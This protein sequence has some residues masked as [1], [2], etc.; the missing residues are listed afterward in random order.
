M[1][2]VTLFLP[3]EN[4]HL[5]KDVGLIPLTMKKEFGYEARLVCFNNEPS[6]PALKTEAAGLE[7]QF[8][9][10]GGKRFFL[11]LAVLD[12][13]RENA[14]DIDVL[15]LFH[16]TRDTLFY[17]SLYKKYNPKG[18]LYLK[19]D[20]YN[21]HLIAPKVYSLNFFKNLLLKREEKQF[22]RSL[23]LVS[24]ENKKGLELLKST[25]PQLAG[26]SV[27]LPNGAHDSWLD[28]HFGETGF[29][30]KENLLLS[31]GRPGDA[32]KNYEL[33][34]KALPHLDLQNWK[35]MVVGEVSKIFAA[36]WKEFTAA[37]PETAARVAFTGEMRDREQLYQLYRK[38]KVFFL[39][40]LFESF[41]ISYA[42]AL[43]FGCYLVGN[44]S[45]AAYADL[46][47][48]GRY[49]GTYRSDDPRSLAE[50]LESAMRLTAANA[51]LTA[52][53]QVHARK[54]FSWSAICAGL[55]DKISGH[56]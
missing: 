46:S 22:F 41:G 1:R 48:H 15:H 21:Q 4:V 17:G 38:A 50:E 30:S 52:A 32:V 31:V 26:K 18:F 51:Q 37:F 36:R 27:Y 6:Y 25:Y 35:M 34:L 43:Y 20:A 56:G 42:E 3:T 55:H 39:P 2:W 11:E 29:G 23:D 53:I 8:L 12:F 28:Q 40:S 33:L 9:I 5:T 7:L 49:G 16:L 24:I 45:M 14:A 19:M 54:A 13:L 44:D 10:R 47:D